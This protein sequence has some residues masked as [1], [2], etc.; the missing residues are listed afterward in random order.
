MMGKKKK[1]KAKQK[2]RLEEKRTLIRWLIN[3]WRHLSILA[4]LVWAGIS[5]FCVYLTLIS[6]Y[7]SVSVHPTINRSAKNPFGTLFVISNDNSYS[8]SDVI[9]TYIVDSVIYEQIKY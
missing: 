9:Y 4:K 8:L 1:R 3:A 5:L 6:F 2:N 7:P